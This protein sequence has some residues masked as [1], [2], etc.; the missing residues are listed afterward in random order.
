MPTN[1]IQADAASRRGLNQPLNGRP[2]P[3]AASHKDRGLGKFIGGREG[4]TSPRFLD[5]ERGPSESF[6]MRCARN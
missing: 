4:P 1:L 6:T 3:E 2:W 5:T